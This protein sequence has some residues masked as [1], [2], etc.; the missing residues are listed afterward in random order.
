VTEAT[1][2]HQ[3]TAAAGDAALIARQRETI[4]TAPTRHATAEVVTTAHR[5]RDDSDATAAGLAGPLGADAW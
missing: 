1:G 2:S 3:P 4:Y 5:R